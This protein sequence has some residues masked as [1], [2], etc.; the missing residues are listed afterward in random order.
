MYEGVGPRGSGCMPLS[1][2]AVRRLATELCS[3]SRL[4]VVCT[5]VQFLALPLF[6]SM[7]PHDDCVSFPLLFHCND[8][9]CL[10]C[11]LIHM[12]CKQVDEDAKRYIVVHKA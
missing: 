1:T 4:L 3:S 6:E 5:A 10:Q 9:W 11:S 12:G 7:F 8:M 2:Y